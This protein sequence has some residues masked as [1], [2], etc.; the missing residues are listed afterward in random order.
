MMPLQPMQLQLTIT[1]FS[2]TGTDELM[3]GNLLIL[4]VNIAQ[5][6]I[7]S[8]SEEDMNG[9]QPEELCTIS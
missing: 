8:C 7:R 1:A 4:H 6:W 9:C 2:A 3:E 5:N